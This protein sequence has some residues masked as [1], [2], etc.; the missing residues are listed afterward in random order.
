MVCNVI[1]LWAGWLDKVWSPYIEIWA[2]SAAFLLS[3]NDAINKCNQQLQLHKT[4]GIMDMMERRRARD[5]KT[6]Q[7]HW[8]HN[9]FGLKATWTKAAILYE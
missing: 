8:K 9:V 3:L 4:K 1:I 6:H 7:R 5:S 2:F